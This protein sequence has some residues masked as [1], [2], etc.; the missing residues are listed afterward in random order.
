MTRRPSL[1]LALVAVLFLVACGSSPDERYAKAVLAAENKDQ[2]AFL[3]FFTRKSAAFV[4]DML[5]N[6]VRSK[7]NYIKDP[8]LLLPIG[9]LEGVVID[10]NSALLTVKGKNRTDEIRMFMENDEWSIDV[11]SLPRFWEPLRENGQ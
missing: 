11:F 2:P 7:I 4:R 6:G 9:E 3:S 1:I 5:A 8:F 10:G